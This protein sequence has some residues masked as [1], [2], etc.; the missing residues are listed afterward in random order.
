M[1]DD[2]TQPTPA[3]APLEIRLRPCKTRLALLWQDDIIQEMTAH[4]LRVNSPSADVKGHFGQGG[5]VPVGKENVTI[6]ALEPVGAYALKI[7]F[8]DGHRTGLFTWDYLRGL[9]ET[10]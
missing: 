3:A 1:N 5:E 10:A 9:E 6:T 8:S 7:T 4:T 2:T